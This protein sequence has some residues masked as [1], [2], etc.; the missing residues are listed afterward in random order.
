MR[1]SDSRKRAPTG[2]SPSATANTWTPTS[3]P[4]CGEWR[5]SGRGRR[6]RSKGAE[7]S[8]LVF[9]QV[10]QILEALH[11]PRLRLHLLSDGQAL[12][13]LVEFLLGRR[14]HQE[15]DGRATDRVPSGH[16]FSLCLQPRQLIHGKQRVGSV[17]VHR[18]QIEWHGEANDNISW[19]RPRF[20]LSPHLRRNRT[21]VYGS[22]TALNPL[23]VA[24]E[25]VRVDVFEGAGFREFVYLICG[26]L[27]AAR[28]DVV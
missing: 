6:A 12:Q 25:T 28:A 5:A 9:V 24:D 11:P 22:R 19:S 7:P 10:R 14:V 18:Y 23:G 27:P 15:H 20:A 26:Q 8:F 1:S 3:W 21:L 4:V 17:Q 13:Y 2:D 16:Y